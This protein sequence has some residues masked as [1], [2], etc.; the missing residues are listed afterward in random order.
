MTVNPT[1]NSD[2]R[3]AR[4]S[5]TLTSGQTGTAQNMPG[6]RLRSIVTSGAF[7]GAITVMAANDDAHANAA[8]LKDRG[9]S[10]ISDTAAAF[11]GIP[12]DA[13]FIWPVAATGAAATID[14]YYTR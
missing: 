12:E 11:H 2:Y 5:W 4:V 6:W 13:Q 10:A 9:G 14:A 8:G 1:I 3:F 7:G